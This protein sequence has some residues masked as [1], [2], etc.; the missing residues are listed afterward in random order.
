MTLRIFWTAQN[1]TLRP[2]SCRLILKNGSLYSIS[3]IHVSFYNVSSMN[4]ESMNSLIFK[5][6]CKLNISSTKPEWACSQ[7]NKSRS[8]SHFRSRS[9]SWLG[10]WFQL[11]AFTSIAN[12]F[13]ITNR[14]C[15]LRGNILFRWLTHVWLQC[16]FPKC[17]RTNRVPKELCVH[18]SSESGFLRES[19]SKTSLFS[20]FKSLI[21]KSF[22]FTKGKI[23]KVSES[24]SATAFGT[25][26]VP[27][28]TGPIYIALNIP[29]CILGSQ[30]VYC[31]VF[32]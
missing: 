8:E 16:A 21:W 24:R 30:V 18:M 14:I 4:K 10:S 26:F 15:A 22:A 7:R 9:A 6:C 3:K 2:F 20:R 23:R 12:A 27:L 31:E 5:E 11:C 32:C 29:L 13:P 28:W 1:S 25:W 19:R 17:S